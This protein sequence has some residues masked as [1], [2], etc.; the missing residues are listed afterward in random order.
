MRICIES[1]V[2]NYASETIL[3]D[4]TLTIESGESVAILGPNGAGKTTLLKCID[5][6]LQY[7]RG[8]IRI[9]EENLRELG[10]EQLARRISYVPQAT[11]S[12]FPIKVFDMVLLGR[13]PYIKWNS[14][15]SDQLKTL[16]A[17]KKMC[18]EN[19][20]IRNFNEIS[21][22]Q[23]Q[24]VIIARALAQDTNILLFDEP[25]SNL[26]IRHQIEVMDIVKELVEQ[27]RVTSVMV[28]HDLNMAGRYSDKIVLMHE[29]R[30][31]AVGAPPKIL[32]KENIAIV[33]GVDAQI[34]TV[35]GKPYIIP[36]KVK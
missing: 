26:D 10:R 4:V 3:R 34:E 28:L 27:L 21:G 35:D 30:I 32:T 9:D 25:I 5:G 23:Q 12:L 11:G 24:K 19:L 22:G 33:Y 20:A 8:T 15:K 31:F 16:A 18:V 36:L 7:K 17:M 2:F 13:S 14:S 6:L 29:G 1:L